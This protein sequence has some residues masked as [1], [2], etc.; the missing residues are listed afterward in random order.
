[1]QASDFDVL[2]FWIGWRV[3]CPNPNCKEANE[4]NLIVILMSPSPDALLT[5]KCD[6][7]DE[8]Y[9]VRWT[10][11]EPNRI[12]QLRDVLMKIQQDGEKLIRKNLVDLQFGL[13]AMSV[14]LPNER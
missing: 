1:M 5:S 3:R 7:C 6:S 11:R 10:T 14:K 2:N 4:L 12:Q 9:M 13:V 8:S